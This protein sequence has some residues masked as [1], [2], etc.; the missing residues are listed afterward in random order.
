VNDIALTPVC[1]VVVG[2]PVAD[3][4]KPGA[5]V[6]LELIAL[7]L[8]AKVSTEVVVCTWDTAFRVRF[9]PVTGL[10]PEFFNESVKTPELEPGGTISCA[11]YT[12]TLSL[13]RAVVA[14]LMKRE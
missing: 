8:T 7:P 10:L 13:E 14:E 6:L 1:P 3:V 9:R 12:V 11:D 5:R 2:V 4:D